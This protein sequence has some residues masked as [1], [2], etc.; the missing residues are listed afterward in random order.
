MTDERRRSP[1]SA[2]IGTEMEEL[3]EGY[4]RLSLTVERR[5]TNPNGVMHGGVVTTL[6]DEALGGVIASVRGLETMFAAPH[7][8]VEMNA[9][10]LSGARPGDRIVV[11]GRVIRMGK[12]IAFGE[13][14]ARRNGDT[15]IAK[16]RLTFAIRPGGRASARNRGE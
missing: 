3:R 10:F 6:M 16:G 13:A 1:F 5:H 4:A 11:E 2:F 9:S 12:S 8:T 7:A 15:L 14:E